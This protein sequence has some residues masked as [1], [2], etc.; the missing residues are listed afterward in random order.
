LIFLFY[1]KNVRCDIYSLL[2]GVGATLISLYI[3]GIETDLSQKLFV[4][5][6][7]VFGLYFFYKFFK[8]IKPLKS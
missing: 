2:P 7:I 3:K 4:I 6:G 1:E 8:A 5:I